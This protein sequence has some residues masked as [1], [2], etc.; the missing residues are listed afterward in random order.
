[1]KIIITEEQ[2]DKFIGLQRRITDIIGEVPLMLDI[3][4]DFWG[5]NENYD[6]CYYYPTLKKFMKGIVDEICHQWFYNFDN[7]V[8]F[9]YDGIGYK[10]FIDML[11]DEHGEKIINFYNMKTK[12][13]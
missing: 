4:N 10:N 13:C 11:M 9:I 5:S 6:F 12:D 8:K 3:D 2:Y 1:M 7:I